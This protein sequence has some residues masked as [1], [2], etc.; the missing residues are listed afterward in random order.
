VDESERE[1]VEETIMLHGFTA[2]KLWQELDE[3]CEHKKGEDHLSGEDIDFAHR[4]VQAMGRHPNVFDNRVLD[5]LG[6]EIE[7]FTDHPMKWMEPCIVRLAGELRLQQAI[8]LLIKKLHEDDEVLTPDCVRSL[9]KIGGD[10]VVEAVA[11]DFREAEWAFRLD[12]AG[13][14]E[15]IH[16]DRSVEQSLA[17]LDWEE[18]LVIQCRLAQSALLNFA[19]QAIE[20]ARQLVLNT[21]LDPHVIEVRNDLLAASTLMG[22]QVPEYEQW[23]ED[24]KHDVE[25]RRSWYAT[26]YL[27]SA[28]EENDYLEDDYEDYD[29][30]LVAPPDTVVREHQKIGRNEPCPCGSG[31]K[32]KKCCLRKG[33]GVGLFE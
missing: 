21:E 6:Q 27:D 26:H 14:F 2:E 24:S 9:V 7:D 17:L 32:Y 23:K 16:T 11:D 18:E 30:D 3:F 20:P 28:N 5:L 13:I 31:K 1:S 25:F 33:N 12:S 10:E 19:D 15:K 8:P 4:L 29:E 22:V